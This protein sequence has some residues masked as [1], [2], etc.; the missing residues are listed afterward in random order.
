M[1]NINNSDS[2]L[3]ILSKQ[4]ST[5]VFELFKND[6]E[7][8]IV[9]R[10]QRG[11]FDKVIKVLVE[12]FNNIIENKGEADL[13]S[14][15]ETC[16]LFNPAISRTTLYN[17]TEKGYLKSSRVAGFGRR[18]FYS[19]REVLAQMRSIKKCSREPP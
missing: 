7:G 13:I 6:S 5:N 12:R 1:Y 3:D 18:V 9:Q 10:I 19:R 8:I 14:P 4:V 15:K 16:K 17:Y 11:E 2:I